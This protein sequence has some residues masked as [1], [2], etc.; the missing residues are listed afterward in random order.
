MRCG[1]AILIAW[2]CR[3]GVNDTAAVD[4]V[5]DLLSVDAANR[6]DEPLLPANLP[7]AFEPLMKPI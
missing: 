5:P 4:H 1:E 7:H 2:S 6:V 3:C